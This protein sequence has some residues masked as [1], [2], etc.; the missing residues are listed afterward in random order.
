MAAERS[1][2]VVSCEVAAQ[3]DG[4]S[5]TLSFEQCGVILDRE[6]QPCR[7]RAD[8]LAATSGAAGEYAAD[9]G[10]GEAIGDVGGLGLTRRIE[11]TLEVVR[12]RSADSGV[13]VADQ[14]DRPRTAV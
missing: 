10:V 5:G 11:W 13:G 1:G 9:A 7:K 12:V 6:R 3:V 14:V 2:D 4:G 8:G